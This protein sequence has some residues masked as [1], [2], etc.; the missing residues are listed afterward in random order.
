MFNSDSTMSNPG[1]IFQLTVDQINQCPV[2]CINYC[3]LPCKILIFIISAHRQLLQCISYHCLATCHWRILS[4]MM[5]YYS[6]FYVNYPLWQLKIY[7]NLFNTIFIFMRTAMYTEFSMT[8]TDT[9]AHAHTLTHKHTHCFRH[10]RIR[11]A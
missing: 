2:V 7:L 5:F 11:M 3:Y 1:K 9:R 6:P 4:M 10:C 8:Y